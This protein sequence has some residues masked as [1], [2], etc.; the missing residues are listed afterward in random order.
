MEEG[1]GDSVYSLSRVTADWYHLEYLAS[2][3]QAEIFAVLRCCLSL[4]NKLR[5]GEVCTECEEELNKLGK[6]NQVAIVL[7]P[8]H[9]GVE[10]NEASD[11]LANLDS[12]FRS[13]S[14]I[15]IPYSACKTAINDCQG[16]KICSMV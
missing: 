11:T 12:R 3:F 1:S 15:L 8:G 5:N 10:G 13:Q 6:Y 7:V 14:F 2:V 9:S 4:F 16:F